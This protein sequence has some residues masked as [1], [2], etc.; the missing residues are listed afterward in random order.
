MFKKILCP[1][2]GSAPAKNAL[3]IAI[4]MAKK[5]EASLVLMHSL[6][7]RTNVS[8][9]EQFAAV[10][11]MVE[12][13]RPEIDRLRTM[14]G[15]LDVRTNYTERAVSSRALVEIG[16]HILD[17][18]KL[19]AQQRGVTDIS[20]LLEDGDPA[21]DILRCID[22]HGVD[23]VVMGSRGLSDLKALFLGSVSHKVTNRAS[24]T[25]IAVK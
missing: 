23:C 4:D 3:N 5:N 24:C 16:Q 9:L 19:D 22:E 7:H 21:D 18:A 1:V 14:D 11:G 12:H 13:I 15:R 10:E 20:T 17:G 2:D 6:L 25:C 8:E